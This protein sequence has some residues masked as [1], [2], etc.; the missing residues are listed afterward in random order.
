MG[1]SKPTGLTRF[2]AGEG[3]RTL[4]S[5]LCQQTPVKPHFFRRH[6]GISLNCLFL[7]LFLLFRHQF[8][9]QRLETQELKILERLLHR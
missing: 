4:V 1:A 6:H 8:Y 5:F 7:L 9:G 3:N 2:G